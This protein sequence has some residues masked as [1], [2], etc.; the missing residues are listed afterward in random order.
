MPNP[1][2][3]GKDEALHYPSCAPPSFSLIIL[4][5]LAFLNNFLKNVFL[6]TAKP[7]HSDTILSYI[8]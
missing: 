7:V 6:S 3:G 1:Q 8:I 2:W 4:L 5:L